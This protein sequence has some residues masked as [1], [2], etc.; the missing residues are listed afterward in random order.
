MPNKPVEIA[1]LKRWQFI[2]GYLVLV[3]GIAVSFAFSSAQSHDAD[4]ALCR[5]QRVGV[6]TLRTLLEDG[7]ETLEHLPPALRP[8][9]YDISREFYQ[10]KIKELK[11]P[12]PCEEELGING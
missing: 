11:R 7:L 3:A 4:V 5:Q 1:H 9:T 2:V 10:Q 8:A 6:T 12:I